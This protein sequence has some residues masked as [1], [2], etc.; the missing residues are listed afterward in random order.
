MTM[1]LDQVKVSDLERFPA[2]HRQL[3]AGWLLSHGNSNTRAA[4][5]RDLAMWCEFL[6]TVGVDLFAA[7]RT[8]VDAF[9]R[10]LE[11]AKRRPTTVARAIAAVSSW[12]CWCIQEE[13]MDSN[14]AECVTRPKTGEAHVALTPALDREHL[15][16]LIATATDTQDRA[17]V[18]L[19]SVLGLRVSEAL[20]LDVGAVH[21]DRGHRV[22]VVNGKGDTRT[23]MPVPPIVAHALEALEAHHDRTD[24]PLFTLT[25][26]QRMTRHSA[27]AVLQ[28]LSRRAGIAPAVRPH[29]LR[30]TAIT[31]ALEAGA[32]LH[33][34]QDLARHADPRTTR[35]YDRARGSLD[36]H[37]AYTLAAWVPA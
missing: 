9:A 36:A 7:R 31:S 25:D 3:L 27:T 29:T 2:A 28:R 34:V 11:A 37:A 16:R 30:A 17:L 8:H 14:P 21:A 26:G 19:L 24:G 4:Y 15:G 22:I 1:T 33:Q 6:E 35:R 12:S 32:S 5:A 20:A 18:L 13:H 23:T 10:T